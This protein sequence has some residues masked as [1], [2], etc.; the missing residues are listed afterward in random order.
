MLPPPAENAAS[1]SNV[2]GL[3]ASSSSAGPHQVAM[4]NTDM[5]IDT[6]NFEG[7][8]HD[9]RPPPILKNTSA[10][11]QS[12]ASPVSG[13]IGSAHGAGPSA[14]LSTP[15]QNAYG[16]TASAGRHDS[17]DSA[18]SSGSFR[19]SLVDGVLGMFSRSPVI[20][21]D[22]PVTNADM[23]LAFEEAEPS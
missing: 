2:G 12:A 22:E 11:F 1:S 5:D 13:R 20:N 8:F 3:N 21:E 16:I 6:S 17:K 7:N 10:S 19:R 23:D 4:N 18:G 14:F 15:N 9:A